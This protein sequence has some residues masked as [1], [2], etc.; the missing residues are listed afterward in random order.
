MI[1][2]DKLMALE[3]ALRNA[4]NELA[5]DG[6]AGA[7]AA[8]QAVIAYIEADPEWDKE[9]LS[10]PLRKVAMGLADLNRGRIISMFKPV[11]VRNR[12]P[13][14]SE[15]QLV[16]SSAAFCVDILM[17]NGASNQEA[18]TFIARELEKLGF[19]T[20]R[21]ADKSAWKAIKTWRDRLSKLPA[22]DQT[23]YGYALLRSQVSSHKFE[24]L[25]GAR[26]IVSTS[27]TEATRLLSDA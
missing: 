16:K 1:S 19:E 6:R 26:S 21:H 18:C 12:K 20:G 4:K 15:R 7:I 24:S 11:S 25:A 13:D 2:P 22:D 27:L 8:L 17:A 9:Y 5:S 10:L 14:S 23:R 3:Q